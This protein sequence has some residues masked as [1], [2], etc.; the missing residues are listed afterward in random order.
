MSKNVLV[1][2]LVLV[3]LVTGSSLAGVPGTD[4]W[5]P[6]L[7]RTPGAHGSQWYATVWIHNPGTQSAQVHISY[8]V[9]NRANNAPIVQ[10]VTVD[11]GE[12]L[13][14][15]DVFQDVFGLATAKG[16][17]R[18]QSNRRVVV[19]ARSYNLTASG[20]ADSQGQFLAGMPAE[21]ALASG[22]K[23]SIPGI[24][25]PADGSFRCN[26]AL[27]E[28][29][30]GTPQ[31]A[32]TLYDRDGVEL[33]SKNYTLS[34]YEPVQFNLNDLGSGMTVDGGR[35]DVE[36]LS[37][38]GKV[39]TFASMLG[40]G[41]LSQD[42]STLEMEYE[43]QAGSSS[44]GG[45]I[46]AVAA[47]EGLTGGGSSGDVTLAIADGGV[48]SAK[49][50]DGTVHPADLANGAVTKAK[51]SATGGSNGQI[52]GTDGSNLVW[53]TANGLTLPYEGTVNSSQPAITVTNNGTGGVYAFVHAGVGVAGDSETDSGVVG[54]STNKPGVYGKSTSGAGVLG[55]SRT[56]PGVFGVSHSSQGVSGASDTSV[57]VYGI[58]TE[59]WGVSG[60]GGSIGVRGSASSGEGVSGSS[61]SGRGVSGESHSGEGVSG[62]SI[63]GIGIK[64]TSESNAGMVAIST[65]NDALKA[66]SYGPGK[67]SVSAFHPK[68]TGFAIQG[69]N[70]PLQAEGFIGGSSSNY[71]TGVYGTSG[72]T[73][74]SG[75]LGMANN[76]KLATGIWG[77]SVSGWAGYFEGNVKVFG[78][79]SVSGYLTTVAGTYRIDSPL[80]PEGTYLNHSAV[81]S[82]DMMDI[83][84]GNVRTD[85]NGYAIVQ[86]PEYF[87]ALN[88]DFRYQLT[89]IGQFA[90]A[91]VAEEIH[92]GQFV[93]RTNLGQVK[94][95]WQVTGI[96]Q[97]PWS[98]AHRVPVEQVK[99]ENEQGTYL[100]PEV[101]G[102]PESKGLA[103]RMDKLRRRSVEPRSEE[104]ND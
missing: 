91:I 35:I 64:G 87:E 100:A 43:L 24:T 84:N 75:V 53:K 72:A 69:K 104:P 65:T 89:V 46:T 36:V 71:S 54:S 90:Q 94:V 21:L 60:A 57:G 51:L 8:C 32:V 97:D 67:A 59:G 77:K 78:D 33:E 37:G 39:L 42:P 12:T 74:G 63:S 5:V 27:V 49:I 19:S 102:Q 80:D 28:T 15:A 101:Y 70:G 82:P 62:K 85:A 47:G 41:T 29:D 52:L 13:K 103:A 83:Y 44:G 55:E 11:P 93:I 40:N 81:V 56:S 31:V 22:E 2:G 88:R 9:R 1:V 17:L 48:T 68:E 18:F 38:S 73:D 26:F 50:H 61:A 66:E 30:G 76:G 23:T 96:R 10:T 99:P 16:A 25:Q 6:S 45:D 95:S 4:L 20:V 86:L 58:S 92:D 98:K 14:L 79:V 3:F 34:P 7:A